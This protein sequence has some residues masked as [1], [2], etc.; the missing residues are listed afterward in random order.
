MKNLFIRSLSIGVY[1]GMEDEKR[2]AL[3]VATLDGYWS[4]VTF[5]FYII[6]SYQNNLGPLWKIHSLLLA[7][8]IIGLFLIYKR[9]PDSGRVYIHLAGLFGIFIVVDAFGVNSGIEYY[10]FTSVFVPHITFTLEEYWKGAILSAISCIVFVAQQILGM[11]LLI[12]PIH[13]PANEK[14]IAIVFVL[15]FTLSVLMVVRWRLS[16]A[17]KEI[18]IKHAELVHASN[19]I[20]LGEMSATIAHEINNP[21][22]SLSLQLTVLKDD[23]HETKHDLIKKMNETIYKMGNMIHS[24]KHLSNKDHD[25]PKEKF[26][27]SEVI[28]DVI[29]T[30]SDKMKEHGINLYI[31][32]N[33]L[34]SV[35]GHSLQFT[36]VLVN[37]LNNSV[38]AVRELDDKWIRIEVA[39]KSQFL[40]V[41]VTDSG[42]GIPDEIS[43]KIMNPFFTTK[44]N[45]GG[46]GLGLSISRSILE[47]N[48]GR[49]YYDTNAEN[50][51][52]IMLLPLE[53]G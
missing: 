19:M 45:G 46:T 2:F 34:F 36:Q 50:T 35:R 39:E 27:L 4:A 42:K 26:I 32:G 37:L 47:K 1:P 49:L 52:F 40:Q 12:S 31:E 3:Q 18:S 25:L 9:R 7:S 5:F 24:L 14:L 29:R 41:S 30:S 11:G 48:K 15:C 23:V 21:L 43:S 44:V 10:Y 33:S 13:S 53:D 28:K 8:M 17:K 51:K 6:H 38:E 16:V 20:A 22:Q